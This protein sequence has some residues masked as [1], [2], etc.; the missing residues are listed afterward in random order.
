MS[1][2]SVKM[3]RRWRK[4]RPHSGGWWEYREC[5]GDRVDRVLLTD[6]GMMVAD[7]DEWERVVGRPPSEVWNENYFE[8]TDT[9]QSQMPGLWRQCP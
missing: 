9:D 8:G 1:E 7:D 3:T 4:S 5:G 2:L 6:S